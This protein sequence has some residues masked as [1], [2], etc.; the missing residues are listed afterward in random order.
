MPACKH[1]D[2]CR[3]YLR[4]GRGIICQTCPTRCE[5]FEEKPEPGARRGAGGMYVLMVTKTR[6]VK[7][8]LAPATAGVCYRVEV[9]TYPHAVSSDLEHLR[10][11]GK[12]LQRR[13]P[14]AGITWETCEVPIAG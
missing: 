4:Q 6:T 5:H 3:E 2:V 12:H 7:P 9:E 13:Y 14:E 8:A 11:L 10:E 1:G